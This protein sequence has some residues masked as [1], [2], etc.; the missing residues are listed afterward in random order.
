MKN[1]KSLK[2][3]IYNAILEDMFSLEYKPG[4]ILNEKALVEKYECSKSPVRE[5]LFRAVQRQCVA[6]YSAIWI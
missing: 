5:A 3:T 4:D 1:E 6:Q 2:D